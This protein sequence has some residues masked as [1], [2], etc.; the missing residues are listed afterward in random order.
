MIRQAR[1]M[2][3]AGELGPI[4]VIQVEYPQDWLATP[5]EKT[6]TAASVLLK[7]QSCVSSIPRVCD[8][9]ASSSGRF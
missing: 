9:C 1:E 4:R 5:L 6:G 3:L 7:K 2:T 8:D